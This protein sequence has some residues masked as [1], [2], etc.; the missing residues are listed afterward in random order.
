MLKNG[1]SSPSVWESRKAS[2]R[3]GR[4]NWALQQTIVSTGGHC[5]EFSHK[6]SKA[7]RWESTEP[8]KSHQILQGDGSNTW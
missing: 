7:T 1:E 2:H 5:E 3:H 6:G 4:L 8:A